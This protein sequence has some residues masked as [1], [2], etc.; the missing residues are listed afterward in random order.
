M[1]LMQTKLEQAYKEYLEYKNYTEKSFTPIEEQ[2]KEIAEKALKSGNELDV[3]FEVMG[4]KQL[5]HIDLNLLGITFRNV[6]DSYKDLVEVDPQIKEE[7]EK[8]QLKYLFAIKNGKRETVDT[9]LYDLYKKQFL[10]A[11]QKM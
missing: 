8:I 6:Y 4:E 10:E 3:V 5:E 9:E 2:R 1:N 11:N 7:A